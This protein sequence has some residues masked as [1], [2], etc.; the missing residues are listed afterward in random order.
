MKPLFSSF[1]TLFALLLTACGT[2]AVGVE[3]T[4]TTVKPTSPLASP[5]VPVP[6]TPEASVYRNPEVGFELLLPKGWSVY[7]PMPMPNGEE[8][9]ALG[10][11]ARSDGGPDVSQLIIAEA[12]TFNPESFVRA[13]CGTCD[14]R[15]LDAT[16]LGGKP[17]LH[18]V[19]SGPSVPTLEWYFV[20]HNGKTIGL[21]IR[22]LSDGVDLSWVTQSLTFTTPANATVPTATAAPHIAQR[23]L[24]VAAYTNHAQL[25]CLDANGTSTLIADMTGQGVISVPDIAADGNRVAYL[26]QAPDDTSELWIVDAADP[27]ATRRRVLGPAELN[28]GDAT[29]RNSPDQIAWQGNTHT[30]FFSTRFTPVAEPTG[31]GEYIN[32][33]L[34]K[35]DTDATTSS[36]TNI[37]PRQGAG[38]F[39]LSP[40]G[41]Y[42]A[43]SSPTSLTL[44]RADGTDVHVVVTFPFISTHSEYAYKPAVIWSPGSDF[45][46]VAIPSAEPMAAD[47]YATL[48]QVGANGAIRQE[49][50]VAGNFV[51][52]GS[53]PLRIAPDGRQV[54]Y[55]QVDQTN[56]E[57]VLHRA[58]FAG[59]EDVVL[60]QTSLLYGLGWSPNGAFFAYALGSESGG[61]YLVGDEGAPKSFA[62]G[63]SLR[64]AAW[65]DDVTLYFVG[66]QAGQTGVYVQTVG[67]ATPR[68][69][70]SGLGENV[71]LVAK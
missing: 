26:V 34:W 12:A 47:P 23:G 36:A 61:G 40:D 21:S 60:A 2:L 67:E 59:T 68:L 55:S 3:L 50:K 18:A 52:G 44:M 51:F 28:T 20:T 32:N 56:N 49:V 45:F 1:L 14:P 64:Y 30:L 15:P 48:Y 69:L 31:P 63:V 27:N 70:A 22:N 57:N 58:R 38:L 13:Y 10:I 53:V 6:L 41:Q 62:P 65:A 29:V 9:Y 35:V 17:A 33:D 16:T 7:G 19:L 71:F 46:S 39:A 11:N 24:C 42:V 8:L 43:L 37:V 4:P 54:V 66:T 5:S 25:F